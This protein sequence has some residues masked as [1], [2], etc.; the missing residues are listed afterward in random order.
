MG[1]FEQE[2]AK[3]YVDLSVKLKQAAD[4]VVANPVE[5]AT[6]SL[7]SISADIG[8][9]PVTFTRLA[10][11]IGYGSYEELR[12]EMRHS[13]GRR[14]GQFSDNVER[15][16]SEHADSS[17]LFATEHISTCLGNLTALRDYINPDE[18]NLVVDR[19]HDSRK[20][21]LLGALGS[22]G[23][24]EYMSYTADFIADNWQLA[25]R[26]GSS[27]GSSLIGLS[28]KDA[29]I[30]ITKAP[31]ANQAIQAAELASLNGV[32]VL[33]IT[34]SHKCPSLAHASS[35]FIVPTDSSHFF[36][37][38]VSTIA[39]I[40]A[41]IGLLAVKAGEP[42]RDRLSKVEESNRRLEYLSDDKI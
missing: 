5:V 17:D 23:A 39:L 25:G 41:M 42:A 33:I 7:R 29:L 8:V 32:F 1:A 18:F 37:S 34:D 31:H 2:L 10:R 6:R 14:A 38:Y 15:L 20:V 3:R 40:E 30:V 24:A 19:L 9:T 28:D 35:Y 13:V 27:L 21:V 11:A 22:S 26:M 36:S 16:Q 4:Y 12:E